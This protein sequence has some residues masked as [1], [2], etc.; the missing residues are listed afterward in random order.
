MDVEEEEE[1]EEEVGGEEDRGASLWQQFPVSFPLVD[2]DVDVEEE[3]VGEEGEE[4]VEDGDHSSLWRQFPVS[5]PFDV[6]R[7]NAH[8]WDGIHGGLSSVDAPVQGVAW[9]EVLIRN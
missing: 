6:V 4:E 5:F 8:L 1:E 7:G 9:C 2:V 3:E